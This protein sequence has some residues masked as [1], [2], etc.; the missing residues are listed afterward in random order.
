M[1]GGDGTIPGGAGDGP[2]FGGDLV[3]IEGGGADRDE[4]R[5]RYVNLKGLVRALGCSLA[6]VKEIIAR[7]AD[8]P[9]VRRGS[10][11]EAYCFD[12]DAVKPW[13]EAN[14]YGT[15][16][17]ADD[18]PSERQLA[19]DRAAV[20]KADLLEI[21]VRTKTGDL[22]DAGLVGI[23]LADAVIV[24]ARFLDRL[25]LRL[26]ARG[27]PEEWVE[28]IR[29]EINT[30]RAELVKAVKAAPADQLLSATVGHA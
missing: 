9:M 10:E 4:L 19:D 17:S 30:A 24:L 3:V 23:E 29:G 5:R 20:A 18:G 25:P 2:L 28:K 13:W 7:R 22:V 16:S 26:A 27:L 15:R 1:S 12:V 8:F 6:W 11:T 21:Q 14:G